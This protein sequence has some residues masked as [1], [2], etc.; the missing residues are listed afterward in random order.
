MEHIS[1]TMINQGD[2]GVS[3][4]DFLRYTTKSKELLKLLSGYNMITKDDIRPSFCGPSEDLPDCDSDLENEVYLKG[5]EKLT[6]NYDL[7]EHPFINV[8]YASQV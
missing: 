2:K 6:V 3:M 5:N 8:S 4:V 1:I 7:F